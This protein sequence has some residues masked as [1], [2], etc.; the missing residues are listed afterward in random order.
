MSISGSSDSQP[1][2]S[3]E[4]PV[5]R[6]GGGIQE[7]RFFYFVFKKKFLLSYGDAVM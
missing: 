4:T 5:G 3:W 6:D 7:F 2:A 1:E